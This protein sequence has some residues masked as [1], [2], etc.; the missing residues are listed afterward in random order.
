MRPSVF[1][2]IGLLMTFGGLATVL[3]LAY[4]ADLP[5]GLWALLPVLLGV[6]LRT[7]IRSWHRF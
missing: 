7:L 1:G 5:F 2:S 3:L 4:P 6:S